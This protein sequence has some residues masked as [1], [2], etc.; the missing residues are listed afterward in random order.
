MLSLTE[1]VILHV[2]RIPLIFS[3][4][5]ISFVLYSRPWTSFKVKNAVTIWYDFSLP[6]C[7]LY[8]WLY[9]WHV[10][11]VLQV[12]LIFVLLLKVCFKDKED[13]KNGHCVSF[14]EKFYCH[15]DEPFLS[16]STLVLKITLKFILS[17][18]SP[19]MDMLNNY[20]SNQFGHRFLET[21]VALSNFSQKLRY[22]NNMK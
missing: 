6:S 21:F 18:L 9:P 14:Q 12:L 20:S 17:Y 3:R 15:S 11:C 13:E 7:I 2:F 8:S 16:R 19:L 22:C 5:E 4:I 1:L 10:C